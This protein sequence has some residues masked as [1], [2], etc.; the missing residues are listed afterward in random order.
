M[1]CVYDEKGVLLICETLGSARQVCHT[2]DYFSGLEWYPVIC[3]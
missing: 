3:L 1:I 2:A